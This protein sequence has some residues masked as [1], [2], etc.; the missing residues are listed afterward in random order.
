MPTITAKIQLYVNESQAE[1]L[2]LTSKTYQKAC[3]WLSEKVVVSKNL[4]QRQLNNLYYKELRQRFGLKSQMA[5]S[6]MKTVIASYKSAQ[7]N[8]HEWSLVICS[9]GFNRCTSSN[10]ESPCQ[11]PLC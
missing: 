6:V 3:N 10:R 2:R 5:Q 1:I 7:A 11:K 8:G 9:R 4:N